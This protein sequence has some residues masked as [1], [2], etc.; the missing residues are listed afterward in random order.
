[1][2]GIGLRDG[3]Y[4]YNKKE[5]ISKNGAARYLDGTLI[6]STT[7]LLNIVLKFKEFTGCSLEH[8]VNTASLNPAKLLKIDNCKG[9]LKEGKDA[10]L[11]ILDN[12]YSVFATFVEGELVY[13]KSSITHTS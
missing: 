6:G 12:D 10:D 3:N 2:H 13:R 5:Y 4:F 1:M 9:S 7:S 8:A 11:I